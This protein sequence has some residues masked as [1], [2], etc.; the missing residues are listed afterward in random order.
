[1]SVSVHVG[2]GLRFCVSE[3]IIKLNA[4]L[5]TSNQLSDIGEVGEVRPTLVGRVHKTEHCVAN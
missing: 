5:I 3:I 1:M 4:N 2:A